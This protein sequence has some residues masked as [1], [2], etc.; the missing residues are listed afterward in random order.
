MGPQ[1]SFFLLRINDISDINDSSQW[2][3]HSE[4][5]WYMIQVIIKVTNARVLPSTVR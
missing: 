4:I 1:M 2:H 5:Q 3:C